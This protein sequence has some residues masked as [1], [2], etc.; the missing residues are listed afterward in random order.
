[1][2]KHNFLDATSFSLERRIGDARF[3][4]DDKKSFQ[5]FSL[6]S[7]NC[8]GR[9][10]I[11]PHLP[12]LIEYCLADLYSLAYTEI[13]LILAHMIWSFDMELQKEN[14]TWGEGQKAYTTWVK[15]SLY[16]WLVRVIR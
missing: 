7:R 1:M 2:S 11:C 10:C 9:K 8:L 4:N 12:A 6:G 3:I 5:S 16:V 14:E 13:R 15:G